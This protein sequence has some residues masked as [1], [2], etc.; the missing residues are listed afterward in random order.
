LKVLTDRSRQIVLDQAAGHSLA[1]IAAEYDIS[2]QRVQTIVR[3]A[4]RRIDRLE[5][6]L[7]KSKQTDEVVA[8][9][10][11]GDDRQLALDYVNWCLHRLRVRGVRATATHQPTTDGCIFIIEEEESK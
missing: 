9:A 3:D 4:T 1:S 7:I 10:I 6:D 2:Y 8:L 5:L 11:P